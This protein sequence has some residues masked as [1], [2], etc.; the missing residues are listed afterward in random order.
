MVACS[1]TACNLGDSEPLDLRSTEIESVHCPYFPVNGRDLLLGF[2]EVQSDKHDVGKAN[3]ERVIVEYG[4]T[5]S[6]L[7]TVPQRIVHS[8]LT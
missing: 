3:G 8:Q 4:L 1:R 6:L 7:L 2:F 5:K